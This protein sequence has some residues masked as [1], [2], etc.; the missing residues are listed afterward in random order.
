MGASQLLLFLPAALLLAI[1]PGPDNLAVLSLGLAR[2]RNEALGFA[3]GCAAGCLNH[4]LLAA[5]GV[6]AIL[7]AHPEALTALQYLG[8]AYL[9]WLGWRAL[10]GGEPTLGAESAAALGFRAQ[11]RRGLIANAIN[12]KVGLFFLAF[13]P[14]FLTPGGWP[15]SFQILVLGGLFALTAALVFS[16]LACGAAPIGRWLRRKPA[17]ARR[18]DHV[19][20]FCFIALGLRLALGDMVR[21]G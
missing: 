12:P 13:L 21:H 7:R 9:V 3:I 5:L 14:Q 20:G 19:C 10:R 17:V 1:A 18:L 15:E 8:G 4:T 16:I 11:L 2:G 6:F